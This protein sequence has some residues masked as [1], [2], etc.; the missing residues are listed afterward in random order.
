MEFGFHC[1]G[2]QTGNAVDICTYTCGNGILEAHEDC[3]DGNL[4][5]SDGCLSTCLVSVGYSCTVPTN[6]TASRC[7]VICGDG[8][9]H[10]SEACEDG[11]TTNNDGC[12]S[13]CGLEEGY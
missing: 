12:S 9:K 2:G 8:Q 13:T 10:S 5:E 11:N 1:T 7:G 3:D 4:I 6:E